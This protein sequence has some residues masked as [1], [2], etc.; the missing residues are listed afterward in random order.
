VGQ[1]ELAD[2]CARLRARPV[3]TVHYRE[4]DDTPAV[5][6]FTVAEHPARVWLLGVFSD[7]PADVLLD[8]LTDDEA[9]FLWELA[10]DP[11]E[12]LDERELQ[13]IGL[14]MLA[15]AA[16][17]PWWET[18]RLLS[19]F[20]HDRHTFDGLATDRGMPDPLGW[21][22]PRLC[23]WIEYRLLSSQGKDSDRHALTARLQAPPA[24]TGLAG[25][26]PSLSDEQ[27]AADWLDMAGQAPT[28]GLAG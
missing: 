14:S 27:M 22:L 1:R 19:T 25:V 26:D 28:G 18:T 17:R 5:R 21:P 11:D 6:E 23:N 16:D 7:E 20:V 24:D 13:R 12:E 4:V 10:A 15:A 8:V 9:S 3:F 2:F